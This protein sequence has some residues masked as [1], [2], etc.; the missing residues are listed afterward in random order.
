VIRRTVTGP[1]SLP[2]DWC[3]GPN[4]AA[5]RDVAP[6][7][8]DCDLDQQV[9]IVCPPAPDLALVEAEDVVEEQLPVARRGKFLGVTSAGHVADEGIEDVLRLVHGRHLG[10][11]WQRGGLTHLVELGLQ[12]RGEAGVAEN[13]IGTKRSKPARW[14]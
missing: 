10:D 3:L 1:V 14:P 11:R 2:V 9:H 4:Q 5:D 6:F 8:T 12:K 7:R 13:V